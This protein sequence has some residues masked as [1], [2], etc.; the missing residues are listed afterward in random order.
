MVALLV[1]YLEQKSDSEETVAAMA[2]TTDVE[3]VVLLAACSVSWMV[4]RLAVEMDGMLVAEWVAERVA[5]MVFLKVAMMVV[6][7]VEDLAYMLAVLRAA[8]TAGMKVDN[9]VVAMAAALVALM[10]N[11]LVFL[12]V[13]W[14]VD[15]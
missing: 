4:V 14:S 9:T 6:M 15:G 5:L 2:S 10:G 11:L 12:M 3:K 7:R 1:E 13:G 8:M